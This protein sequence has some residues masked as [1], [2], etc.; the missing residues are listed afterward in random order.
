MHWWL[1]LNRKLFLP[2]VYKANSDSENIFQRQDICSDVLPYEDFIVS[3]FS[4]R[5]LNTNVSYRTQFR[6]KSCNLICFV[7]AMDLPMHTAWVTHAI[8]QAGE[9]FLCPVC[10]LTFKIFTKCVYYYHSLS[11]EVIRE[12]YHLP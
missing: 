6:K 10:F 9:N 5:K 7:S 11:E 3:L 8:V 12:S 2:C 1:A 4:V